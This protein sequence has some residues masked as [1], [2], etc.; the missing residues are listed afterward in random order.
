MDSGGGQVEK[1]G[2]AFQV[3]GPPGAQVQAGEQ[4][5][6]GRELSQSS[7]RQGL[8]SRK[9]NTSLHVCQ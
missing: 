4:R 9:R 8:T 5:S 6:G 3:A 1:Q 7:W 2:R